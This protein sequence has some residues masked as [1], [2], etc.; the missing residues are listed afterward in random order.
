M[1]DLPS[2]G[3]NNDGLTPQIGASRNLILL[4]NGEG[5]VSYTHLD[6]YKRQEPKNTILKSSFSVVV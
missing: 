3:E 6:V 2:G 1:E 4:L 5:A